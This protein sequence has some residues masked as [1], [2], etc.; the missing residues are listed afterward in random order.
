MVAAMTCGF[1]PGVARSEV[2]FDVEPLAA[3][4]P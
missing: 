2:E 4:L 3:G 1:D